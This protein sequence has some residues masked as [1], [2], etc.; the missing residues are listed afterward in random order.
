LQD[1]LGKAFQT[2]AVTREEIARLTEKNRKLE[3]KIDRLLKLQV[4]E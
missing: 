1:K 2:S 4:V 3:E